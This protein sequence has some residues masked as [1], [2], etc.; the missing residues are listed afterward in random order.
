ML[1]VRLPKM[2]AM[3]CVVVESDK[4]KEKEIM[5][6]YSNDP[7]MPR[8]ISAIPVLI[9]IS[10]TLMQVAS[11][12]EV[13]WILGKF[14]FAEVWYI[15]V[16]FIVFGVFVW[17]CIDVLNGRMSG[18]LAVLLFTALEVWHLIEAFLDDPT[19]AVIIF[20]VLE[21]LC[22]LIACGILLTSRS[23]EW[24]RNI[25]RNQRESID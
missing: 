1:H 18:F 12:K 9:A 17:V 4:R 8:L 20:S 7:R 22:W 24:F 15:S 25:A 2:P 21:T 19:T 5:R 6:I 13:H 16:S 11:W 3:I 10:Y 23:R 14:T